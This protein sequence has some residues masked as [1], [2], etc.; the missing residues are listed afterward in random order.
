MIDHA[1]LIANGDQRLSANRTCW[2]AQ[3]RFEVM[4]T[5]AFRERGVT[6]ERAHP[7]DTPAGHGFIASQAQGLAV[8][9]SVP[10]EAPLVVAEGV[11]QFSQQVLGGLLRHRGPILTVAN[12]E[13]QWPGLV[14]LLNLNASLV[15]AGRPYQTLWSRTFADEWFG[16]RLDSWLRDGTI[17]HDTSHV[18]PFDETAVSGPARRAAEEVTSRLRRESAILGVFDEG[19]M[20][21]YN[22]IIPDELLFPLGIYKE[23]LSQSALYA[24]TMRAS[25][26]DAEAALRWLRD[27][28]MTF[29]F[30]TDPDTDLTRDQVLLQLRM[31][32]AV[33]RIADRFGCDVI[34]IQYQLGLAEV[35]PASDLAEGLLN[36]GDRPPVV[37]DSGAV[38]R[39]GSPIVHFNEADEC[40]GVDA[41]L[42]NRIHTALGQPVETTLHD[43]RWGDHDPTGTVDDFVW[44]FEISGSVPPAH[45]VG[46]YAGTDSMRQPSLYFQLGGGTVRGVSRP[47]EL[48]WSRVFVADGELHLDIGRASAV[49][50]PAE[51]TERRWAETT[52]EWPIMHAV[53]H[54]VSRDQFMARHRS[55]HIQVAYA[56]DAA[57]ADQVLAAKALAAHQLGMRVHLCGTRR[58]GGPLL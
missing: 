55:N 53:L 11:W 9:A 4:L 31:Y 47:G 14:G 54:G 56:N 13:G 32:A 46:G 40:A 23:R 7:A 24:E 57:A 51:E 43:V 49:S 5:E 21:M 30:G 41:L 22:A 28:G 19:C 44:V 48:V 10:A 20:G 1:Y 52:R 8:L 45:H 38:I 3:Q 50:L 25:Q 36:N 37:G 27:R 18:R 58:D 34:G 15:K 35:L 29:H 12:W 42:T 16:S 39:D 26:A 17:V 33:A 6:L 2:P